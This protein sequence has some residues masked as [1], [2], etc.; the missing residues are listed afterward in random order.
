MNKISLRAARL[1]S[2]FTLCQV[3]EVVKHTPSTISQWETGKIAPK[4]TDAMIL[5]ELYNMPLDRI[6]FG[7]GGKNGQTS[8]QTENA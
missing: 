7:F 8:N 1:L 5:A 6:D 2:G 4:I 3:A